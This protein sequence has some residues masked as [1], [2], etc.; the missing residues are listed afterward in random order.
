M[1]DLLLKG[2]LT[3]VRFWSVFAFRLFWTFVSE[4]VKTD[5]LPAAFRKKNKDPTPFRPIPVPFPHN[6]QKLPNHPTNN[7]SHFLVNPH[8]PSQTNPFSPL[9]AKVP[10][11]FR[12]FGH[13]PSA[14]FPEQTLQ[15]STLSAKPEPLSAR[16][17]PFRTLS[18]I[19][20]PC[21]PPFSTSYEHQIKKHV[22]V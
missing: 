14:P 11:P 5:G 22:N 18:A 6:P 10:N 2:A 20:A 1:G 16:A 4:C 17:E 8:H 12:K 19:T 21:P 3:F 9:S 15:K 7:I 13:V